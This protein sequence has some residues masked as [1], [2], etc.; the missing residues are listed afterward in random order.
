MCGH[1]S[2]LRISRQLAK[3]TRQIEPSPKAAYTYYPLDYAQEPH[4]LYLEKYGQGQRRVLLLGMNP[5]PFGMTQTGVPFGDVSRVRDFL[6][7]TGKVKRP[8]VE[9]PKRPIE[10]FSCKKGEVSGTRLWGWVEARFKTPE[11]F[12]KHYFVANYCPLVF[13]TETGANLTPDKLPP[14]TRLAIEAVCDEALVAVCDELKPEWV[15]GIGAFAQK[16]AARALAGRKEKIGVVL[17]PSPASPKANRGWATE[18]ERELQA[19]GLD[20]WRV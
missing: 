13:M 12:F 15:V 3:K 1:V 14:E 20:L 11:A 9:H 4:E 17:H 6:G 19:L 18:V 10:G 5:G 8:A 2:L 16:Q 7:V